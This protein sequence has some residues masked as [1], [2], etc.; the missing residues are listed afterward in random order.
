MTQLSVH[1]VDEVWSLETHT[2][3]TGFVEMLHTMC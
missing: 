3:M 2:N 1:G